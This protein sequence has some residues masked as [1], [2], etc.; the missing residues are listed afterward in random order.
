MK[1]VRAKFVCGSVIEASWGGAKVIHMNAV[2]SEEGENK[3]F[4]DTTP[5][6]NLDL[7]I[8][9]D[10]PASEYFEQGKEYYID[11]SAADQRPNKPPVGK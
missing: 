5:A 3:D 11:I 10:A 7:V 1:K 2:Y 9:N 8:N 6:G 4:T